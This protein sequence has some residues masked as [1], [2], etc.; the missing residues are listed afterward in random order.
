VSNSVSKAVGEDPQYTSPIPAT[1]ADLD[2][3]SVTG[4]RVSVPD[5]GE[6]PSRSGLTTR[7]QGEWRSIAERQDLAHI[8]AFFRTIRV[9]AVIGWLVWV[10]FDAVLA[11]GM[12]PGTFA[13][14]M[15]VRLVCG[16]GML[17]SLSVVVRAKNY[18]TMT[19]GL[20]ALALSV[21]GGAA[22]VATHLGGISSPYHPG[23]VV[24]LAVLGFSPLPWRRLVPVAFAAWVI[25]PVVILAHALRTPAEHARMHD[26]VA[27]V[28][29][30]AA[31]VVQFIVAVLA[32]IGAGLSWALRQ[33]VFE[34][35]S[36]GRYQLRRK[37]G[38]GGMGEVWAA[39]HKG[40]QREVA[41]KIL[42]AGEGDEQAARRFEREVRAMT[43]LTHPNTVRVFD[44][45]V[46]DDNLT[47]YAMEL[48]RGHTFV[49][50]VAHE[51]VLPAARVVY[52]CRQVARALAEAHA[53]AMVHRDI[54]PENLFVTDA[55]GESDFVK[56]LDFGIVRRANEEGEG[57][58]TKTGAIAGTPAYIAP[59][60]V[61]GEVADARADVYALG[62]VMYFLL[63][64][65]QPF[66]GQNVVALLLAHVNEPVA[67]PHT[68]TTNAIPDDLEA[69]VLRCLAKRSEDRPLD[70]GALADALDACSVAGQWRPARG[71]P[72]VS[73]KPVVRQVSI[74]SDATVEA[75][76]PKESTRHA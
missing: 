54:K 17:A 51:G 36:I 75:P 50:L 38:A 25:Y 8:A 66:E 59:E 31:T 40:L 33:Q 34:S 61:R 73:I 26:A 58:L 6:R 47:Y 29:L 57:S 2:V 64:G 45:G 62:A 18:S 20:I 56:V 72:S 63:T 10:P 32:C 55:G 1:R 14:T 52:L 16:V 49:E 74:E 39:W 4:V 24:V 30:G 71:A 44:Y 67:A 42:R 43:E 70:A 13:H 27:L 28:P 68:L 22:L 9:P 11:W 5:G 65:R 15:L 48:L 53:R 12:Y 76:R 23:G 60:V 35:R 7:A 41:L 69:L 37:L 21:N 19:F 46:T 3:P